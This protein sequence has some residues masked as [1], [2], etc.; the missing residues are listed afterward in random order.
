[1]LKVININS[2][3]D[4]TLHDRAFIEQVISYAERDN[5]WIV[6][7]HLSP[8]LENVPV[9]LVSTTSM[10]NLPE[11]LKSDIKKEQELEN[12]KKNSNFN[13][14]QPPEVLGFYAC[15]D[16]QCIK[17][18]PK[19]YPVVFLCPENIKL[20]C[21]PSGIE[22]YQRILAE[23]TVH[24]YAHAKMDD[25]GEQFIYM[26]NNREFY[27]SIEEPFANWFVLKY[28]YY[29]GNGKFFHNVEDNISKQPSYYRLGCNF[30][31]SIQD[32][33]KKVPL[34]GLWKNKKST[35]VKN[36]NE[37]WLDLVKENLKAGKI[38]EAN[39]IYML[40]NILN[41]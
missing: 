7:N 22:E 15:L 25:A 2:A 14:S 31:Y 30:Y 23:I 38:S 35:L 1:M 29:Y 37:K 24:E 4:L 34:W 28:F 11:Y 40:N 33:D 36:G 18:A 16:I 20:L 39:V 9:F 26:N 5:R 32:D 41:K 13:I 19:K 12:S 6:Q 8:L 3:I 27:D 21:R 10:N 17:D